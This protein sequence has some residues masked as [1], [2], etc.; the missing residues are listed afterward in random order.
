[1][2]SASF[3]YYFNEL[4]SRSVLAA[5]RSTPL[6]ISQVHRKGTHSH[7]FFFV[8]YLEAALRDEAAQLDVPHQV[9]KDTIV[10]A[11][12]ADFVCPDPANADKIHAEARAILARWSLV[13]N[14]SKTE[15]TTVHRLHES[16]RP[17]Q[18]TIVAQHAQVRLFLTTSRTF[19]AGRASP[20]QLS[21]ICGRFGLGHR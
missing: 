5:T 4:H 18:S 13:M 21:N 7:L 15:Y 11:D 3:A 9:L 10:D 20:Q 19:R 14:T 17:R 2:K 1:M 6:R 8:V 16:H 12:D